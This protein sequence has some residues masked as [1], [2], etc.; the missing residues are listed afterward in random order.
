MC[1]FWWE[2]FG[3]MCGLVVNCC[4]GIRCK[5]KNI[6]GGFGNCFY[7]FFFYISYEILKKDIKY[8]FIV[9]KILVY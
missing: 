4:C 9:V 1:L 3:V 7:D 2:V 5:V 6:S 8:C